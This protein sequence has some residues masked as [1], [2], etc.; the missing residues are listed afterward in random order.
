MVSLRKTEMKWKDHART[1]SP[2]HRNLF[3]YE[4]GIQHPNTIDQKKQLLEKSPMY[5]GRLHQ[6]PSMSTTLLFLPRSISHRPQ[7]GTNPFLLRGARFIRSLPFLMLLGVGSRRPSSSRGINSSIRD[8][9]SRGRGHGEPAAQHP[10][11]DHAG[12]R[13]AEPTPRSL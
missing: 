12:E 1:N 2:W 8:G 5:L 7:L 11:E 4:S 13:Q 3:D 9:A 6:S 10:E